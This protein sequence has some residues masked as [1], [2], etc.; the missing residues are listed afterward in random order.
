MTLIKQDKA[1]FY[2]YEFPV[3]EKNYRIV[4]FRSKDI[5]N[6]LNIS[7]AS[8]TL[9]NNYVDLNDAVLL[10]MKHDRSDFAFYLHETFIGDHLHP[11]TPGAPL[12]KFV[13]QQLLST[14][15]DW[16]NLI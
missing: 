12:P 8:T 9:E 1:G 4:L 6:I 3:T 10:A 11:T 5:C 13:P 7:K 16:S 2:Y 14:D 15:R